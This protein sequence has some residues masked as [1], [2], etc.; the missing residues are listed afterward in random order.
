M[1]IIIHHKPGHI[2]TRDPNNA[3][4]YTQSDGMLATVD[5]G[6]MGVFISSL[7]GERH[8]DQGVYDELVTLVFD[9][10]DEARRFARAA[11]RAMSEASEECFVSN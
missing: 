5:C 4:W 3:L 11:V 2:T 9:T 6:E 7:Y 10:E 1:D 8:D